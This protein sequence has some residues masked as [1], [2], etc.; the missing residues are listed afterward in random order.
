MFCYVDVFNGLF[1]SSRSGLLL[2]QSLW[3]I[4]LFFH[5][6]ILMFIVYSFNTVF[7]SYVNTFD[8]NSA[9]LVHIIYMSR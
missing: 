1:F 9:K 2:Q 5:L 3:Y 8:V 6:Y 4:Y 7:Y